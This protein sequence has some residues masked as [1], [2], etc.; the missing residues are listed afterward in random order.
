MRSKL[1][2]PNTVYEEA[3]HYA[4]QK[5]LDSEQYDWFSVNALDLLKLTNRKG[6]LPSIRKKLCFYK[7]I[8]DLLGKLTKFYMITVVIFSFALVVADRLQYVDATT[9]YALFLFFLTLIFSIKHLS[10]RAFINLYDNTQKNIFKDLK[11]DQ[12]D[13]RIRYSDH[14]EVIKRKAA[15]YI[16]SS[17]DLI[18]NCEHLFN[19][20]YEIDRLALSY[21]NK[22][23]NSLDSDFQRAV[24]LNEKR[25]DSFGNYPCHITDEDY[26]EKFIA[27]AKEY[28]AKGIDLF[29]DEVLI[30]TLFMA[31]ITPTSFHTVNA[32]RFGLGFLF[33]LS[34]LLEK[35]FEMS[36]MIGV[37][38]MIGICG[39]CLLI[40]LAGFIYISADRPEIDDKD[41][42]RLILQIANTLIDKDSK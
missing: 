17:Q 34:L 3:K 19:E 15:D 25:K 20:K 29:N 8:A 26:S 18:F 35:A 2:I 23:N 11:I 42:E 4:S 31:K 6:A 30:K 39:V 14:S 13:S 12:I 32:V 28:K 38:G 1:Y 5:M 40:M 36:G 24:L 7:F 22:V 16:G 33:A 37:A 21:L 41:K 10:Y 27:L 9:M